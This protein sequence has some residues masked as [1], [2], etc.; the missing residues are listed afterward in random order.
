MQERIE[1][2]SKLN[3]VFKVSG[4]SSQHV[5]CQIVFDCDVLHRSSIETDG[6]TVMHFQL[7]WYRGESNRFDPVTVSIGI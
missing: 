6:R 3:I 4:S 1:R 5:S 7:W 2:N